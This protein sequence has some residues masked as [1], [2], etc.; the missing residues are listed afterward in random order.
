MLKYSWLRDRL[1]KG[2]RFSQDVYE[3]ALTDSVDSTTVWL[4]AGC[5]AARRTSCV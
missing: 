1:A 4:D 5:G 3:E 2:L